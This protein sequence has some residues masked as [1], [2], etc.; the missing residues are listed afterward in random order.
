MYSPDQMLR[1]ANQD[2]MRMNPYAVEHF[3]HKGI[4][5]QTDGGNKLINA[6]FSLHFEV[7]G[8]R[9]YVGFILC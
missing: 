6:M 3:N 8:V 5:T 2:F 9:A 7:L 4:N 1:G